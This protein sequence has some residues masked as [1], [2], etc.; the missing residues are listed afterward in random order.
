MTFHDM[1]IVLETLVPV[2]SQTAFFFALPVASQSWPVYK[3]K[4]KKEIRSIWRS[5]QPQSLTKE[6]VHIV[7]DIIGLRGIDGWM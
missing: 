3:K 5:F 6:R 4:K 7:Y 2:V 1:S